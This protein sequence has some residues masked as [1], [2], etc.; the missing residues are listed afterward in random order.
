MKIKTFLTA[1]S[2]SNSIIATGYFSQ[3]S[4]QVLSTD[5]KTDQIVFIKNI[6]KIL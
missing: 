2:L 5:A 4:K 3:A 6:F 1:H